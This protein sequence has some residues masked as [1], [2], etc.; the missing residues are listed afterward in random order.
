MGRLRPSVKGSAA[1]PRR[2]PLPRDDAEAVP[3]TTRPPPSEWKPCAAPWRDPPGGADHTATALANPPSAPQNSV[4]CRRQRG[5]WPCPGA[6]PAPGNLIDSS[7]DGESVRQ[8]ME[9]QPKD[10]ARASALPTGPRPVLPEPRRPFLLLVFVLL[11]AVGSSTA[12]G[13][14]GLFR[15]DH[16]AQHVSQHDVRRLVVVTHVRRLFR[17]ELLL[18]E[19]ARQ[20]ELDQRGAELDRRL[21]A[22]EAERGLL[23]EQLAGLVEPSERRELEE[24][25]R[26]HRLGRRLLEQPEQPWEATV[27]TLLAATEAHLSRVSA[28]ARNQARSSLLLLL[29]VSAATAVLAV[30]LGRA[31]T[32]R[33]RQI[34]RDLADRSRQ[35]LA[36]VDSVPSLLLVIAP[37]GRLEFL[38]EKASRFLGVATSR[39]EANPFA[40]IR[41]ESGRR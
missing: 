2:P 29:T 11:A 28:R 41:D 9:V 26:Q 4:R 6:H 5:P 18:L 24:L 7:P 32:Q 10:S 15:L 17:S 16:T 21:Q 19:Q 1:R 3:P 36:V 39:L 35:L 23:L 31:V 38:P 8:A 22:I 33:T 30:V 37:D 40:W 12:V 14:F 20:G 34:Q 27:A 13:A 25:Q